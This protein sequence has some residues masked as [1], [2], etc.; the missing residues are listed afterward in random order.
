M[1]STKREL[2]PPSLGEVP[3]EQLFEMMKLK[4]SSPEHARP[5][6][7]EFFKRYKKYLWQCCLTQCKSIPDGP[8]VAKDIFQSTMTKIYLMA[9]AFKPEKNTGLK[10][11]IS[12]VAKSEFHN[13]LKKYHLN[14]VRDE[15]IEIADEESDEN[16]NEAAAKVLNI[17][18][19]RLK[20]LLSQLTAREY[21]VLMTC[22]SYYQ[23][24]KPNAHLPD[25]EIKKLCQEFNIEPATIRQI[26]RRAII[27][28]KKLS[29]ELT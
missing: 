13:Y 18:F 24:D 26:K 19:E 6:W 16:E 10:A 2:Q 12:Q 15:G 8:S 5:A 14:F 3:D 23:L 11:W 27:K 21:K 1:V 20:T 4:D 17:K 7:G 25:T 22:M 29:L 28:L 9:E